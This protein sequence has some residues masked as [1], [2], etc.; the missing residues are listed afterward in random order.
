[1]F[2]T[3]LLSAVLVLGVSTTAMAAQPVPSVPAVPGQP[4][5]GQ[6]SIGQPPAGQPEP[7]VKLY[8]RECAHEPW[9]YVG[10]FECTHD[11]QDAAVPLQRAGYQVYFRNCR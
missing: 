11:A 8:Y 10:C 9:K 2:K 1:M 4:S 5:N 3:L 7:R 6:P